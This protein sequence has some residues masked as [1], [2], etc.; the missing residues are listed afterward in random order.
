MNLP[1]DLQHFSAP[2]LLIVSDTQRATFYL[3]H[4]ETINVVETIDVPAEFD[5]ERD[6][7]FVSDFKDE[8]REH[9]FVARVAEMTSAFAH[10]KNIGHIFIAA[11]QE[12]I[13]LLEAKLGDDVRAFISR[14]IV[15]D[16]VKENVIDVV[17]RFFA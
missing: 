13:N 15:K 8:P 2:T 16:L 3:A 1:T 11:P 9:R 10:N 6:S 7:K 17:K 14:R 5:I 12:I 4:N